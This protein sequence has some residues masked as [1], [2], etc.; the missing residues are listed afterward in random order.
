MSD[1]KKPRMSDL[2]WK[3]NIDMKRRYSDA[4]EQSVDH[5]LTSTWVV[6][7]SVNLRCPGA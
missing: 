5:R 6:P 7:V 1:L 2:R 3:G 4:R